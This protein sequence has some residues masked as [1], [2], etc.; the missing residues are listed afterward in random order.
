MLWTLLAGC[1]TVLGWY[2]DVVPLE[3]K[4]AASTLTIF[5]L[6]ATYRFLISTS[7]PY[8]V[9]FLI[10]V[11]S[12]TFALKVAMDRYF[13]FKCTK[14]CCSLMSSLRL[15]FSKV[16]ICFIG[17]AKNAL[18]LISLLPIQLMSQVFNMAY[19]QHLR[20]RMLHMLQRTAHNVAKRNMS[21]IA[22]RVVN[23]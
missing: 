21:R 6:P 4:D 14:S 8:L 23:A 11:T 9:L 13:H 22:M 16:S 5:Y 15:S 3:L 2:V 7:V 10:V 19:C 20:I 12:D 17:G 1:I 18:E